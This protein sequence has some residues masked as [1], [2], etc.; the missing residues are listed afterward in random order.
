MELHVRFQLNI[1]YP[2]GTTC[3]S[4]SGCRLLDQMY[5]RY[6][7]YWWR[8]PGRHPGARGLPVV[9]AGP[10][11]L[12]RAG[13]AAQ[14]RA[15]DIGAG[16]GAVAIR[17]ALGLCGRRRCGTE[18]PLPPRRSRISPDRPGSEVNVTVADAQSYIPDGLYDVV[19]N[20]SLHY[21]QDKDLVISRM[22][23]ATRDGGIDV[24][25]CGATT[26]RYPSVMSSCRSTAMPRTAWSPAAMRHGRRNSSTSSATSRKRRTPTC[27]RIGIVT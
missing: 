2:K 27:R 20:R 12:A 23:E 9:V 24:S 14:G 26:R 18:P 3:L 10:A 4:R 25:P 19:C 1:H 7:R 22:Q 11:N 6:D 16:G 5:T 21:I 17:L 8:E 13:C 15:L